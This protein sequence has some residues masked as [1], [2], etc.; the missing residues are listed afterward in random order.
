MVSR[1]V[2]RTLLAAGLLAAT[3]GAAAAQG[4]SA[5]KTTTNASA[6][7]F[8]GVVSIDKLAK[9]PAAAAT[10][11][12]PRFMEMPP[13]RWPGHSGPR[14]TVTSP[15]PRF[16]SLP[17]P[18]VKVVRDPPAAHVPGFVALHTTDND[19]ANGFEV[20]PPDQGLAVN[21]NIGAEIV[22]D[23]VRFFNVTTGE[24]LTPPIAA[25]DFFMADP[26]NEV[27]DPQVFFDES[28]NRWFF[29]M[30]E[31]NFRTTGTVEQLDIAVSTTG[32]P[33]GSYKI[34]KA[35]NAFICGGIACLPDFPKAGFDANGLFISVNLFGPPSFNGF[36]GTG[37]IVVPKAPLVAG[38]A[39]DTITIFP[40]FLGNSF[41]VQPSLPRPRE[42]FVTAAGGTEFLLEARF[43]ID[44]TNTVR[45][46]G[47]RNTTS[48]NTSATALN[49]SFFDLPVE[50]YGATVPAAEPVI[51]TLPVCGAAGVPFL[52]AGPP[53]FSA[54]VPLSNGK[55]YGA[56]SFANTA[57]SDVIAFFVITPSITPLGVVSAALFNQGYIIPPAGYSLIMPSFAMRQTLG[58][59]SGA[60]GFTITN[61]N[62]ALIGGFPSAAFVLVT[63]ASATPAPVITVS[64]QGVT[65]DD[66]I[67][68]CTGGSTVGRWGD[69]GAAVVDRI[70]GKIYT[71]A[72]NVSGPH[73]RRT[74]W[75]TFVTQVP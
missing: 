66:D 44:G 15:P 34:Y 19:T 48:L 24:P 27:T 1:N 62:P 64:G 36:F 21:A 42:R 18:N 11:G 23:V 8:M 13:A 72:E 75:G 6:A 60:I 74:N 51:G 10:A 12:K 16:P 28:L 22:N 46:W 70:S 5:A 33:L 40:L 63:G 37:I 58:V 39:A 52:D 67:S 73:G 57:K 59:S 35:A 55:L 17:K 14:G 54:T 2:F 31:T 50:P 68:G 69:Y 53:S 32:D 49:V 20:T 45:V 56:L 9:Q 26:A 25:G 4:A 29:T 65:A 7:K 30:L 38:A 47:I 41:R 71:G 3:G 43:V 61:P